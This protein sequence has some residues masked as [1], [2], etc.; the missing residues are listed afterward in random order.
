MPRSN[1]RERLR[2]RVKEAEMVF[3][4]DFMSVRVS[5]DSLSNGFASASVIARIRQIKRLRRDLFLMV[6]VN[7]CRGRSKLFPSTHQIFHAARARKI[8]RA[9][10]N[11]KKFIQHDAVAR[12]KICA[13]K[14]FN[15]FGSMRP[16]ILLNIRRRSQCA[17]FTRL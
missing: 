9:G 6:A 15:P 10:V 8:A 12:V 14:M 11:D 7:Q 13:L 17:D 1:I 4:F 2:N 5:E 16:A 3:G